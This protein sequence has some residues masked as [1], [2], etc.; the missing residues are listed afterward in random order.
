VIKTGSGVAVFV[1]GVVGVKEG[2]GV[3][4]DGI[5]EGVV[6]F[7]IDVGSGGGIELVSDAEQAEMNNGINTRI[8]NFFMVFLQFK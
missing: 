7:G 4:V 8:N 5:G 1:G 3:S 6:V 2:V